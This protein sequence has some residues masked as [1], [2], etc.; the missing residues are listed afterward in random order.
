MRRTLTA[1]FTSV[2]LSLALSQSARAQTDAD[3]ARAEVVEGA[4]LYRA[5]QFVEAERHFRRGLELDPTR[6][7]T[8]LFIARAIHQQY[9][10]GDTSPENVAMA[11]RAL[12]LSRE[13]PLPW[14][15]KAHLLREASKLAEME[16][17]AARKA[18]YDRRQKETREIYDKL[19][20]DADKRKQEP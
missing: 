15:Y 17:D 8:R 6:R 2:V 16:G 5:G 4:R 13:D 9:K 11:E 14:N 12:L 3:A 10:L 7:N 19:R 18:D 1:I 20:A